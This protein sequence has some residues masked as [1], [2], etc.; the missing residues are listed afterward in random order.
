MSEETTALKVLREGDLL[1][2]IL[3]RPGS[4]NALNTELVESLISAIAADEP[5]R[6]CVIRAEGKHFCAG[7]DL[8]DIENENDADLLWRFLRIEQMLQ[9]VAHASF[10]IMALAQG[11]VVGAGADLFAACW[12][13]IAAPNAVFRMPGWNFELALGTRRFAQLVGSH[14]ARDA[15][16]DTKALSVS[17]AAAV[18]LVT[19]V[20]DPEAW[21][22]AM[23]VTLKR[24]RSLPD[25][26]L[27]HMLGLTV[28]DTRDQ[29]LAAV[30]NTACRPGLKKRILA[31]RN[32]VIERKK[33]RGKAA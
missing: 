14:V 33:A 31:Y 6:L 32:L 18:G 2:L 17:D 1:T 25:F 16:I 4:A 12:K 30:V 8:S 26:A 11:Q 3:N 23:E 21:P 29:D 7:F 10:P 19:E 13:R 24:S 27:K 15:L 28:A 22:E 5:P 9:M 20:L